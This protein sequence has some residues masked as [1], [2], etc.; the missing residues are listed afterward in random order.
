MDEQTRLIERLRAAGHRLTPQRRLVLEA[1]QASDHHMSAEEI[2]RSISGRYPSLAVDH[3]TIYR[4]LRWL[5][6]A[7]LVSETSLGQSHMVY[8]LLSRHHHHHLVCEACGC[9]IEADSSLLE[10]LRH[11]LEQRYRF[12]ARLAHLSIFGLCAGCQPS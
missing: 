12:S 4:T 2:A 9:V 5:R 6:D 1:L 11:E 3:T 7:D 8:A 10:P